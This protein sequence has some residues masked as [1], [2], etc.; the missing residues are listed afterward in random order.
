MTSPAAAADWARVSDLFDQLL[1][2]PPGE[3][4]T[5]LA[6]EPPA[7]RAQV[8]ALLSAFA[9][10]QGRFAGTAFD[11]LHEAGEGDLLAEAAPGAR[12]GP[13]RV[14]R[15]VGRG[16]MGVVYEA[17]RADGDFRKRVAIKLVGL[18]ARSGAVMR[19]FQRER[20][21]LAGLEHRNIAALVD[22]GVTAEG[23]PYFALEYVEG[24]PI[25]QYV[26]ARALPLAARVALLRQVCGALQYAHQRLVVHRDL[27]PGNI[28][29]TGDGTVKLLDF[30]V[31][32]LLGPDDTPAP[33]DHT[34]VG[35]QPFTPTYA[36]P[37]QLLGD[38]LTT[39]CDLH[40]LGVVLYEVLAGRHPF[41]EAGLPTAEVRRRILDE[42]PPPSGLG[43]DADAILQLAL[44]KTPGERYPS[45][46]AL[47]ED[48]RRLVTGQPLLAR[49]GSRAERLRKFVRRNRAAVLAGALAVAAGVTGVGATLWQAQRTLVQRER[50]EVF[51]GF[52]R[53]M[54]SAPDPTRVG[55][56]ARLLDLLGSTVARLESGEVADPAARADLERTLGITYTA[57][58]V[59]DTAAVLLEGALARNEAQLG[60]DHP[61]SARSRLALAQLEAVRHPGSRADS[62]FSAALA[63]LRRHRP[64]E[65][66][67]PPTRLQQYGNFLFNVGRLEEA[68]PVLQEGLA[69]ASRAGLPA[70]ELVPALNSLGMV[71][72]HHGDAR[73]AKAR[74]REA[75][76]AGAGIGG[77]AAAS[78]LGPLANLANILKLEDSL[79]LADSLQGLAVEQ[80][81]NAYGGRHEVVG[82]TLTGRADI[83]RRRGDLPGAETDL[84]DAVRILAAALPPDH[85][86]QAPALSL[87]GLVLC[88]QGRPAEG[89]PHLQRA[90]AIRRAGLPPGHW[91]I[92]NLESALSTCLTGLGRTTEARAL[93][94][95]GLDG[96][97]RALGPTHPRTLEA[98]GRLATLTPH[99]QTPE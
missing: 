69:L 5:H 53:Q 61:E 74:Y 25:D 14:L 20:R 46:E 94:Q 8:E 58:G 44:R 89:E 99:R 43:R 47:G 15:E 38:P 34:E 3:R 7:I 71:R 49:P 39:A 79:P 42:P 21:I 93:A 68:E 27:K 11:L 1:P 81:R 62:L 78:L 36:S 40:G 33:G 60:P 66:A 4:E 96:L 98:A 18:G 52:L 84:R 24:T 37:E 77:P 86:Q 92:H 51:G 70:A 80:A 10:E 41:R 72:E 26:A 28:L 90:L 57:L 48:L 35:A 73:G 23:V 54:L 83:R 88:E 97:S 59:Y 22:G 87:L 63:A 12:I 91:F 75:I 76:A 64:A 30:G 6:A 85:L 2:L 95:A 17:E 45:A 67:T 65:E 82:A 31:A 19:R 50:A 56:E 29:V 32:K 13:Y 55:R 9:R 16:G